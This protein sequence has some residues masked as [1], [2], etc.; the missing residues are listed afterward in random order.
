MLDWAALCQNLIGLAAPAALPEQIRFPAL[1]DAVV[2]FT[3]LADDPNADPRELARILEKD[4]SL[5]SELLRHVNS[6]ALALRCTI[7]SVRQALTIL[8]PR[9][10]KT[11]VLTAALQNAMQ[12]V[13]SPWVNLSHFRHDSLERAL[14]AKETARALGVDSD[15]AY[16][17]ALLADLAIPVLSCAHLET[18]HEFARSGK[19]LVDFERER[20]ATDHAVVISRLMLEWGF[21]ADLVACVLL[22]H[23]AERVFSDQRLFNSPATAVVAASL[24]PDS[25]KQ[26]PEGFATL[27]RMQDVCPKFRFLEVATAVDEACNQPGANVGSRL[28]LAERLGQLAMELLERRR[29]DSVQAEKHFG[30]YTLEAKLGEGAAGVVYRARHCLLKRP[31]AVKLLNVAKVSTRSIDQFETEVQLT[32][33][34]NNPHTIQ[35]YDYGVTIEGTYYYVMELIDGLTLNQLVRRF[36]PQPEERV[37]HLLIQACGS[38]AEAHSLGLIHRDVKPDNLMLSNRGGEFDVIKVLDFGLVKAVEDAG[39]GMTQIS[40]TPL[41][42]SPEAIN[43][44]H[45]VDGRSDLYALGSVGYFL[46]T[47]RPVFQGECVQSV[48]TQQLSAIPVAPSLVSGRRLSPDL[49]AV[50]LGCLEKAP[51]RRPATPRELARQLSRCQSAAK[52]TQEA[53][54]DWWAEHG[55]QS[56]VFETAPPVSHLSETIMEQQRGGAHGN[57]SEVASSATTSAAPASKF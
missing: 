8:G 21:P 14:F 45:Q 27:L 11:L 3:T 5:T 41:F 44:P 33:Q 20:F 56:D 34:L 22:H 50:I 7:R 52:W 10:S 28:P 31:V 42:M 1:P 36:G 53:A 6:A 15:L 38:L 55:R 49:E 37:I 43:A 18:Y 16:T 25:L 40:G 51:D 9:N 47:G 13:T 39:S 26:H 4:V 2:R 46:L 17:G 48:L 30:N 23:Q 35:I 19:P 12:S 32:S 57:A 24:L 54:A 29:M